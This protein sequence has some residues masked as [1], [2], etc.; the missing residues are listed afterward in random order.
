MHTITEPN[1]AQWIAERTECDQIP[2]RAYWVRLTR[3][4][5]VALPAVIGFYAR[6]LSDAVLRLNADKGE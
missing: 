1:G 5:S 6:T 4:D 2:E 3:G